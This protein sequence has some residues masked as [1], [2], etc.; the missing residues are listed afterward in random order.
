MSRNS[1][2]DWPVENVSPLGKSCAVCRSSRRGGVKCREGA[3]IENSNLA[4]AAGEEEEIAGA[5]PC[6]AIDLEE[7]IFT[8]VA[9]LPSG[10]EIVE[11]PIRE[12]NRWARRVSIMPGKRFAVMQCIERQNS[13]IVHSIA[14]GN[15]VAGGMVLHVQVPTPGL[16]VEDML[17]GLLAFAG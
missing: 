2:Q 15:V 6:E 12:G 3:R 1:M 14:N 9:E 5:G 17:A 16:D 10:T 11:S 8:D 7:F 13:H 4:V